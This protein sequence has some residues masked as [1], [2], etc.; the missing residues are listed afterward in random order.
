MHLSAHIRPGT[1]PIGLTSGPG[2]ARVVARLAVA[3][4]KLLSGTE[5]SLKVSCSEMM[6]DAKETE[7]G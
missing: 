5:A 1:E 4:L 3:L 6:I 7:S 2:E